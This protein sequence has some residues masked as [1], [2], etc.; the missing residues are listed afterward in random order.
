MDAV[1][2]SESIVAEYNSII[3][4]ITECVL[5]DEQII[6]FMM[7]GFNEYK[8]GK[9]SAKDAARMVQQKVNLFLNE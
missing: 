7:E 6:D 8:K 4:G 1:P 3:N 2:L 9:M 5:V